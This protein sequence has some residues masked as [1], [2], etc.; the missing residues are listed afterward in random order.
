[1][2]C[3]LPAAGVTVAH[4]D[5]RCDRY[6]GALPPGLVAGL[7]IARS[8]NPARPVYPV[9]RAG[10]PK[11]VFV[12]FES[13]SVIHSFAIGRPAVTVHNGPRPGRSG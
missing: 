8:F 3:Y 1:M 10:L 12:S 2:S 11:T 4:T 9:G 6:P 7:P 13:E 5:S